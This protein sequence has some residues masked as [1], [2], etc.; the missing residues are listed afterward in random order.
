MIYH[1]INWSIGV[2]AAGYMSP[3]TFGLPGIQ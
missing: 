1:Y 3:A 2:N